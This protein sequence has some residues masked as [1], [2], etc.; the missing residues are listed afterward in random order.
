MKSKR[1]IVF[2]FHTEPTQEENLNVHKHWPMQ[3]EQTNSLRNSISI[4][5]MNADWLNGVFFSRVVEGWHRLSYHCLCDKPITISI[6]LDMP[7][8][9]YNMMNRLTCPAVQLKMKNAD[10]NDFLQTVFCA[11]K[12]IERKTHHIKVYLCGNST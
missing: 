9:M 2:H 7:P 10:A 12:G 3:P 11:P 4:F 1:E 8:G 5:R 6:D